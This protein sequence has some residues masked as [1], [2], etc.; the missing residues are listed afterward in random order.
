MPY[1]GS[2]LHGAIG[3]NYPEILKYG[4]GFNM[5]RVKS[6]DVTIIRANEAIKINNKREIN[7]RSKKLTIWKMRIP[8]RKITGD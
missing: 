4:V 3:R 5:L 2:F 1:W 7:F 8:P 6:G